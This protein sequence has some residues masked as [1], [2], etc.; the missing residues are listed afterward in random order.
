VISYYILYSKLLIIYDGL[1]E[2]SS[3]T[4]SIWPSP[5]LGD[6]G[7]TRGRYLRH[8]TDV[9]SFGTDE[10]PFPFSDWPGR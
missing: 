7:Q 5:R 4:T 1:K 6:F 3:N 9:V 2:F 8:I 10:T